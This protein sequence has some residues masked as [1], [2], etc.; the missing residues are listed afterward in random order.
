MDQGKFP[1]DPRHLG[2]TS[3]VPKMISEPMVRSAQNVHL[4]CVEINISDWNDLSL[5]LRHL[6]VPSGVLKVISEPMVHLVQTVHQSC[7][8]IKTISKWTKASFHLIHAT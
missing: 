8:E 7:V 4:S 1:I 6:G 5:D 2:V 3:V